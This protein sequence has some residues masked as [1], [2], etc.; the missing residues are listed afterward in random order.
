MNAYWRV[1][2]QLHAFLNSTLDGGMWSSRSSRFIPIPIAVESGWVSEPVWT[3]WRREKIPS[4]NPGRPTHSLATILS[5]PDSY[6]IHI[7]YLFSVNMILL[8]TLFPEIYLWEK[9]AGTKGDGLGTTMDKTWAE[10]FIGVVEG[11]EGK[12]ERKLKRCSYCP[13][14]V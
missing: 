13:V 2:V 11:G 12:E 14:I 6:R 10:C 1:E 3:R 4:L 8:R 5:Y 9:T 7:P